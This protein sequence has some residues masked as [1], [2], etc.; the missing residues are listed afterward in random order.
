MVKFLLFSIGLMANFVVLGSEVEPKHINVHLKNKAIKKVL[1]SVVNHYRDENKFSTFVIP[2]SMVS[3]GIKKEEILDNPIVK[4]LIDRYV[5]F[6]LTQ[7]LNFHVRWSPIKVEAAINEDSMRFYAMSAGKDIFH[8]SKFDFDKL[9]ISGEY[10]E[11]CERLTAENECVKENGL[12]GRFENFHLFL[13]DNTPLNAL[14]QLKAELHEEHVQLDFL[15]LM[16]N[17]FTTTS[18]RDQMEISRYGISNIP[19]KFSLKFDDFLMPPPVIKINGKKFVVGVNHIKQVMLD[20]SEFLAKQLVNAAGKFVAKDLVRIL[21]TKLINRLGVISQ[22]F[23]LIDYDKFENEKNE[24]LR[25]SAI[26]PKQGLEYLSNRG[27][28]NSQNLDIVEQIKNTFSRNIY[29][30]NNE[31]V[32]DEIVT[33]RKQDITLGF[34]NNIKVNNQKIK[35]ENKLWNG[36]RTFE[37]INFKKL[38]T[39]EDFDTG[40]SI[41]EPYVN[42]VINSRTQLGLLNR[43]FQDIAKKPGVSIK[44][45]NFHFVPAERS[46]SLQRIK[47]IAH[48]GIKLSKLE[49][50][51][52]SD[53][54]SHFIADFIEGDFEF[55]N[56]N[57]LPELHRKE[58]VIPLEFNLEYSL[59]RI[60]DRTTITL[61]VDPYFSDSS[62]KNSFKYPTN[63][64]S[65][66]VRDGIY[67]ELKESLVAV[68]GEVFVVD[69]TE[70]VQKIPGV[71]LKLKDILVSKGG[72]LVFALDLEDL[73]LKKIKGEL[74]V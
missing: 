56:E 3:G 21:N 20:E 9:E 29:G 35:I 14:V 71:K 11:I 57:F 4:N 68:E 47:V 74:D 58:I 42:S 43:L 19:P 25:L 6:D 31:L 27:K 2:A 49:K 17:I 67:E 7:D 36:L 61:K 45:L 23:N 32:L 30:L 59:Q 50:E 60:E 16:T 22:H 13:E 40:F 64:I 52:P 10:I 65:E 51:G 62:F 41:S 8:T 18:K 53:K 37:S 26:D 5:A 70:H 55:F 24:F 66:V 12:Y 38:E 46:C 39:I 69:L 72:H 15:K 44:G 1:Q 33:Y 48:L 34:E 54:I 63:D 28:S 73:N